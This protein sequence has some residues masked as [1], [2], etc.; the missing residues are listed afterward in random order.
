MRKI[1]GGTNTGCLPPSYP[2]KSPE[3]APAVASPPHASRCY[4]YKHVLKIQVGRFSKIH[5]Y[6]WGRASFYSIG[7][8][9]R[10]GIFIRLNRVTLA[11]FL[12]MS[13]RDGHGDSSKFY[14]PLQ[15]SYLFLIK[16]KNTGKVRAN[17]DG[18]YCSWLQ[19]NWVIRG[20]AGDILLRQ[21]INVPEAINKCS[22]RQ[23]INIPWGTK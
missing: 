13:W 9:N 17:C 22:L 15:R 1:C 2:F 14:H 21:Q 12:T 8:L 19:R 11:I 4:K 20:A 23:Y 16:D 7:N 6:W 18:H 10:D 5:P 3:I